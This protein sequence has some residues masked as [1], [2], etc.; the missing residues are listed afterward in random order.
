M[1]Q[2]I[3]PEQLARRWKRLT[4]LAYADLMKH[5]IGAGIELVMNE[6]KECASIVAN[7]S[8]PNT[9]LPRIHSI[10]GEEEAWRYVAHP[11]LERLFDGLVEL[12]RRACLDDRTAT[13][14]IQLSFSFAE[15]S[16]GL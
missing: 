5:V 6:R 3:A 11:A 10:Y 1:A 7:Q 16:D 14:Q 2:S 12:E 9:E 13:P 8:D 15:R 4:K